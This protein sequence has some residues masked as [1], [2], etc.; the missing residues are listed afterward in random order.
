ME[1][2]QP[3]SCEATFVQKRLV[4]RFFIRIHQADGKNK[5]GPS[6]AEYSGVQNSWVQ[7][8]DGVGSA[9]RKVKKK[10]MVVVKIPVTNIARA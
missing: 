5:N 4:L 7:M 3:D 8:F 9:L 1:L 6:M 10:V 2:V